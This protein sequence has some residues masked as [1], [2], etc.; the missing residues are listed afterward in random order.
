MFDL[1]KKT[2]LILFVCLSLVL[3]G[4]GLKVGNEKSYL[5]SPTNNKQDSML[6]IVLYTDLSCSGCAN[7][8]FD[9]EEQI[10]EK[11]VIT[12][13]VKMK[14]YVLGVVGPSSIRAAQAVL[15]ADEQGQ[16]WQ[17]RDALL[18]DWRDENKLDYS[19]EKLYE[20]A[21]NIGLEMDSFHSSMTSPKLLG[22]IQENTLQAQSAGVYTVPVML[23]GSQRIDGTL[24]LEIYIRSIEKQLDVAQNLTIQ[25][26][27]SN[28]IVNRI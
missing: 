13:K 3:S 9:V 26:L 28:E 11:Y 25:M 18:K 4:C 6:K 21:K 7:L 24:P 10:W 23:I 17:Y 14:I 16:L 15:S 20:I 19:D 12:G 5:S 2:H 22:I 1:L 8:H 27:N